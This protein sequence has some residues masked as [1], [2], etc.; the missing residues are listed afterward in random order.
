MEYG[1]HSMETEINE[2]E[3]RKKAELGLHIITHGFERDIEETVTKIVD[4]S[5]RSGKRVEFHGTIVVV[6]DV[7]AG[8]E[9]IAEEHIIVL[10]A[11]RGLVH[12][13][14]KGNRKAMIIANEIDAPQIRIADIVKEKEMPVFEAEE[15]EVLDKKE[16]KSK[17]LKKQEEPA[18]EEFEDYDEDIKTRAYIKENEIVLE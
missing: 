18:P 10:G 16:K 8:A 4:G 3:R 5:L 12:A 7:N 9:V 17:K 2:E 15:E 6:G 14:A 1:K 11:I 13:G